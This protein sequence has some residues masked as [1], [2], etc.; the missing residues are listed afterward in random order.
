LIDRYLSRTGL[1]FHANTITNDMTNYHAFDE[2]NTDTTAAII[3]AGF[4]NMDRKILTEN[5]DEVAQ[6][7][8]DGINCFIRNE[9]ISPTATVAQ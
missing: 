3:E 5:T 6:G 7:I 8:V 2:I 9:S 4:L 1:P